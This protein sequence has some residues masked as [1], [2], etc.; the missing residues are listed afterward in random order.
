MYFTT[1]QRAIYNFVPDLVLHLFT[2]LYSSIIIFSQ[3][4]DF[5]KL[6]THDFSRVNFSTELS[7][8]L[9]Y[10]SNFFLDYN[11]I[12]I[13]LL[14]FFTVKLSIFSRLCVKHKSDEQVNTHQDIEILH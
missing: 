6:C 9:V 10:K 14:F 12:Y 4:L 8:K 2:F 7:N 11:Y 13:H 3:I 1:I 5:I